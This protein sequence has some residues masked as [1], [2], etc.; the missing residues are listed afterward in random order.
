MTEN[1]DAVNQSLSSLLDDEHSEL[2]LRRV[3][4]A[5]ETDDGVL[6]TWTHYCSSRQALRGEAPELCRNDFFASVQ[7]AIAEEEISVGSV[8]SSR[9]N[10]KAFDWFARAGV[11]ACFTFAFLFGFKFMASDPTLEQQEPVAA[12]EIAASVP[13]GFELPPLNARIVSSDA[14]ASYRNPLLDS[15]S[16]VA[17]NRSVK[18]SVPLSPELQAYLN[19]LM[20]RHAELSSTAGSFGIMPLSRVNSVD[21]EAAP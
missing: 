2:D 20:L 19:E 18:Q 17:S 10:A 16:I 9:G 3:L 4:K 5:A 7:A 11:A 1:R 13:E 12:P 21:A 8:A 6:E 14:S 15:R